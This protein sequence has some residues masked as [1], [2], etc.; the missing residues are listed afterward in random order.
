MSIL[1]VWSAASK[2]ETTSLSAHASP[3]RWEAA[4]ARTVYCTITCA[5]DEW[6]QV[7]QNT[8][9]IKATF[10]LRLGMPFYSKFIVL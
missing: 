10:P 1:F 3:S 6:Q 7:L 9:D 2:T 5:D 8:G 4:L